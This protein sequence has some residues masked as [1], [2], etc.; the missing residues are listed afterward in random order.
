MRAQIVAAVFAAALLSPSLAH[1]DFEGVL[2]SRISGDV[3]GTARTWV[4]KAGMRSET[5][6]TVPEAKQAMAGKTVR[7]TVIM[8]VSEPD[9]TYF[10]DENRKTYHVVEHKPG[11]RADDDRYTAKKIGKDTVAGFSCDKVALTTPSGTDSELCVAPDL[12]GSD[13]WLRVFQQREKDGNAHGMWKALKDAGVKGLPVRWTRPGGNDGHGK[14]Q[15]ELV[16]ATK[17]SVPASTFAIPAD[18]KESQMSMP[19]SSPE[20]AKRMEDAMKNMTPEQ[21]KQM[22]EMMKKFGGGKQS[23]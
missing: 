15:M 22:E 12:G 16:S 14:F 2:V 4:S 1:A 17:Q 5:E 7:S 8:K 23:P 10:L 3:N 20:S 6:L 9:R 21:R 11:E 19:F 18:Y 13:T